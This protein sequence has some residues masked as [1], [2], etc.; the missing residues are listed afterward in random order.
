M[1]FQ[2][3][4]ISLQVMEQLQLHNLLLIIIKDY[5]LLITIKLLQI[6]KKSSNKFLLNS[7]G[8]LHKK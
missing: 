8:I 5:Y 1:I 4:K 3:P 7:N 2:H 6:V